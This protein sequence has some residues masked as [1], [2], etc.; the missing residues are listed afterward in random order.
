M[1]AFYGKCGAIYHITRCFEITNFQTL[2]TAVLQEP[3][4]NA[5]HQKV[6]TE[7]LW[8]EI[9]FFR[10]EFMTIFTPKATILIGACKSYSCDFSGNLFGL[11]MDK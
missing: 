2:A 3:A 5:L 6:S 7:T 10:L 9:I 1:V 8:G 11:M 4:I